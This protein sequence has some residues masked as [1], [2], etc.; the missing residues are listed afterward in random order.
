MRDPDGY[1]EPDGEAHLAR[2]LLSASEALPFL[3]GAAARTLVDQGQ[4]IAFEA[5][6][7]QTMRVPRI[8]FVTTPFEWCDLQLRHAAELTLDISRAALVEGH[9][10]KDASAWNV[11]FHGSRPLFCDHLSFRPIRRRQWWAFGQFLRHFSFPLAVAE[12]TGLPAAR[13]FRMSR[14]GLQPHEARQL[15]GVRRFK[16]K[17]WPLLLYSGADETASV[18][19]K[20]PPPPGQTDTPFHPHLYQY[21]RWSL[22]GGSSTARKNGPW[23]DYVSS[24]SHYSTVSLETK[25]SAVARWLHAT[26]PRWVLD[27]GANS[28]EFSRLAADHG[29]QVIALEQDENCIT[30]LYK[31]ADRSTAIFPL[32]SN[33]ADLCGGSGWLGTE[34]AGLYGRLQNRV[35]LVLALAVIHHLAI[36]ES[37]PLNRIADF[38]ADVSTSHAIVEFVPDND[39]MVQRLSAQRERSAHEFSI[40]AQQAAFGRRFEFL[41]TLTLGSGG[42]VLVLMEKLQA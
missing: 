34:H 24:R 28:G 8:P 41:E 38:V 4:L 30:Q 42:R 7:P 23:L 14:D 31:Q 21:A 5:L 10:L 22:P 1:L 39:P 16:T 33:L 15:L 25:H 27:L 35:Q 6:D 36:S 12:A 37:I 20:H 26:R 9:E 13:W 29:A 2:R 19:S 3:N 17:L 40:A 18:G 32:L 11:L